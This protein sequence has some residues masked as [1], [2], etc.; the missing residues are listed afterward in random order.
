MSQKYKAIVS[1]HIYL[2][3]GSMDIEILSQI[4]NDNHSDIFDDI[5]HALMEQ[6]EP[7]LTN[8]NNYDYYFIATVESEFVE[9]QSWCEIEYNIEHNV[10][11]IT[12]IEDINLAQN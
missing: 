7:V 1:G 2:V 3:D 9:C 12:K 10:T 5:D 11:E 6:L 4:D 8:G